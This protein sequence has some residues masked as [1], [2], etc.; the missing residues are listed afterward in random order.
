MANSI[1]KLAGQTAIYGLCSMI[2]RFLNYL[3]VPLHTKVFDAPQYGVNTEWYAYVTFMVILLTYGL[4]T[5]FFRFSQ[6]TDKDKVYGTAFVSILATSVLFIGGVTLFSRP[7][8]EWMH[9][10]GH[11][12][13]LLWFGWILGLDALSAI[14]FARFRLDNSPLRFAFYK[15]TSV[16]IN[17]FFNLFFLWFCPRF[18]DHAWVQAVYR[19]E[20]GVGYIFL[21][22]LI[23]SAITILLLLPEIFRRK[24][25]FDFGLWKRLIAYSLPLM[26]A[27]LAGNVNE[28]IDRVLL[29]YRLPESAQPMEQ[30]GIYG[31]NVK[32]AILMTLFIQMFRYAAEPFFFNNAKAQN[33]RR[34]I[35]D[36][37]TY[38][39]LFC[40]LIFLCV[41]FYLDIIKYFLRNEVYWEGLGI[42]P[43]MLLANMCLGIYYNLSIWFKLSGQTWYGL[44]IASTG[45]AVSIAG[46]WLLI[47]LWGYHA[48]AWMHLVCYVVMI[49]ITWRLGAKYYPI[50]YNLKKIFCYTAIALCLY[51][52]ASIISIKNIPLNIVKNTVFFAMFAFLIERKEKFLKQI[53][54]K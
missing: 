14:P 23:A 41:T 11:R 31:A 6:H 5:G 20:T 43:V 3:L 48:S 16:S 12:E 39:V 32:I 21:S 33:S 9:Y 53:L 35:A 36:V 29:K 30:L 8:S 22:N 38:F 18:A 54:R 7:L 40:L 1:K 51:G 25:I 49:A 46:N 34:T 52:L 42:V 50:P 10:A 4:E 45:A 24:I 37:M 28:A 17:I 2:P 44:L 47:P 15:M 19:P 27:G 26:A 13:Y